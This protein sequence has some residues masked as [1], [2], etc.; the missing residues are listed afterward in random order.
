MKPAGP[1]S[2]ATDAREGLGPART[3]AQAFAH[4]EYP[5]V[6]DITLDIPPRSPAQRPLVELGPDPE[7]LTPPASPECR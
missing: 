6:A 1:L 5:D 7:S 2:P 4:Y 3:I